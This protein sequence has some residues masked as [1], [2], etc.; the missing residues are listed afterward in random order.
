MLQFSFEFRSVFPVVYFSPH[1][2]HLFSFCSAFFSLCLLHFA[3]C[4]HLLLLE[5]CCL[6]ET[7]CTGSSGHLGKEKKKKVIY[8]GER[9]VQ[10]AAFC[11][12]CRRMKLNL[13]I[14][15]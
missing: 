5:Q 9:T 6:S 13:H 10:V 2:F 8:E 1:S 4:L 3:C 15:V 14:L 7:E 11:G 12:L